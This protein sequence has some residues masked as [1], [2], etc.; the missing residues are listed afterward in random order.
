M[1]PPAKCDYCLIQYDVTRVYD[2]LQIV[3]GK[4]R[5]S[6]AYLY[7]FTKIRIRYDCRVKKVQIESYLIYD[8][9]SFMRNTIHNVLS[10]FLQAFRL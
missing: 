8:L 10:R 4:N 6:V 5:R 3:L 2:T 9:L 1:Q 7:P